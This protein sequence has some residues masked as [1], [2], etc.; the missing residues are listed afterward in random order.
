MTIPIHILNH[1]EE[2]LDR[3]LSQFGSSILLQGTI[4]SFIRGYQILEDVFWDVHYLRQL[5]LAEG[6][7]LDG[8]GSIVGRS[9]RGWDDVKYYL[10]IIGQIGIN[11]SKGLPEQM[12]WLFN[13]LTGSTHTIFMA[14]P[15]A[16]IWMMGNV[17]ITT[18]IE[19]LSDGDCEDSTTD[20]WLPINGAILS[21]DNI[22]PIEGS[23]SLRVEYDD[24]L[25]F[26]IGPA[27]MTGSGF[28]DLLDPLV[29]GGWVDLLTWPYKYARNI[30]QNPIDIGETYLL[31]GKYRSQSGTLADCIVNNGSNQIINLPA[32]DVATEFSTFFTAAYDS[33]Q[34]GTNLEFSGYIDFDELTCQSIDTDNWEEVFAIMD[35][36]APGGVRVNGIGWFD[37]AEEAFSFF[38]DP[39]GKGF[40]D[41]ADPALGGKFAT[42]TMWWT[43]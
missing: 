33:M 20:D 14:H 31:R 37:T 21:K 9:R 23:L 3:L 13:L 28:G 22:T 16:E 40:G 24:S 6:A 18:L 11:T 19:I 25:D 5:D 15:V 7:Q 27:P 29:G 42:L 1:E 10:R 39:T 35:A 43:P 17:P 2:G 8:V 26:V 4:A 36:V 32:N 34:F 12:I 30:L 41:L 38:E